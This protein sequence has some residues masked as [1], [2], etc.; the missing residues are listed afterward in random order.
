MPDR[1]RPSTGNGT[2]EDRPTSFA[3]AKRAA[4]RAVD[5]LDQRERI[6]SF[7]AAGLSVALGITIYFSE[8]HR[9][10]A[11]GQLQPQT[12]LVIGL[13]GGALLAGATFLGRR[14]PVGFIALFLFLLYA[15][16]LILGLPF[17]ALAVWLLWHSYKVQKEQTAKIRAEREAAVS[18][19]ASARG[20]RSSPSRA[21]TRTSA[22]GTRSTRKGAAPTGPE[23]SKR[24]TP[25]KPKP[26]P[27]PQP[28]TRR[29]RR[30]A[31][32]REKERA[33]AQ[34]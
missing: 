32:A 6:L 22:K 18:A 17:L 2:A 21:A 8:I 7:A 13:V 29:E 3:A 1:Q 30:E 10:L 5:R 11:K 28:T 15:Q 31:A 4:V 24:Y 9:H 34:D 16:T 14:A 26:K 12:V 23:A 20:G 27:I 19:R 25:P 33:R